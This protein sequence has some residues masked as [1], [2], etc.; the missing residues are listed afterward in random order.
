M[1]VLFIG[2]SATGYIRDNWLSPMRSMYDVT[3]IPYDILMRAIGVP[4]LN[5]MIISEAEKGYDYIFFYPDGRGQMFSDDL[6][7]KI[8][9]KR[10]IVFH[11]D[12]VPEAWYANASRFDYRYEFIVSSCKEGYERR[13]APPKNM[14]NV[15]Y[16]PW[17]YNPDIY[18]KTNEK[19]DTDIVFL[20][21]NFYK[22]GYYYFDGA[23]RQ[24]IMVRIYE[25]SKRKG[26]S[27][28]VYGAN[29]DKHPVIRECTGGF[30]ED[31]KINGILNRAKIIL[32]L[33]YTMDVNP[34]PHTKLKHFENAGTGSF[35]LVNKNDELE[36]IFGNSFGYFDGVE[37]MIDKINYYLSNDKER[38]K[39]AAK[40]HEISINECSMNK[41]IAELFEKA[42]AYFGH[43]PNTGKAFTNYGEQL[44][45]CHKKL[46]E[47]ITDEDIKKYDYIH[48]N[49][50]GL[51]MFDFNPTLLSKP[52]SGNEK[53]EILSF[54]STVMFCER[55]QLEPSA[56]I[57]RCAG[58]DVVVVPPEFDT[59][60]IV[61]GNE[62]KNHLACV[63]INGKN[64]PIE[65]YL[66]RSDVAREF[67][68]NFRNGEI[69]SLMNAYDTDAICSDY[70]AIG[71]EHVKK[72]YFDMFEKLFE[73]HER[74]A[75][76]GLLGDIFFIWEQW[77]N[78][79]PECKDRVIYL[80]RG[81]IGQEIDGIICMDPEEVLSGR[82]KVSAVIDTA[83]FAGEEIYRF[84]TPIK[85]T[86]KIYKLYDMSQYNQLAEV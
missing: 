54:L 11:S 80:D 62:L 76:Y 38:E 44:C 41:R 56:L 61:Y 7:E 24:E 31:D 15:C 4:S 40:A 83:V 27:F 70:I 65:N 30:A 71:T 73:E 6:F 67:L 63:E 29:W 48:F 57:R 36:E 82:S 81:R 33:G 3:Y 53:P 39:K 66:F 12:D 77:I 72:R 17:G 13:L 14:K 25:E 37:D 79:F 8:R 78:R 21:S 60:Q 52:D 32:G 23:F 64:Y 16:V 19:K 20:G 86:V 35:Q 10:T 55:D 74:I 34:R 49:N 43:Y 18:F 85:D 58:S 50:D 26:F 28:K 5:Q 1:K 51:Y 84:L 46:S 68:N 47:N 22:D 45:I 59:S 75:V 42:N 2:M 69:D 9:G